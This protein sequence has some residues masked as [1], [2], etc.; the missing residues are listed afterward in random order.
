M[1]RVWSLSLLALNAVQAQSEVYPSRA[2]SLVASQPM[3]LV[4]GKNAGVAT[5][6][7]FVSQAKA[8]PGKYRY[9]SS[10]VGT[11]LHIAGELVKKE[12]VIFMTHILYRGVAPLRSDLMGENIEYGFYVLSSALPHLKSGKLV[13]LGTSP[14]IRKKFEESG[15]TVMP[16][17][18]NPSNFIN[19]ESAKVK[20][21]V[22]FAKISEE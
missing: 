9:G 20:R 17:S 3:V 12:A 8:N 14:E 1:A 15:A 19:D 22:E 21:I 18:I 10:G 7:Q 16:G 4:A 11:A 13:G 2:I 6:D 5:L